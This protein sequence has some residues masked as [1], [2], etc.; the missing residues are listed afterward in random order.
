MGKW[1]SAVWAIVRKELTIE[2]HT[3]QIISVMLFFS[4]AAVVTF[5]L[6]VAG[7]LAAAR[8]VSAGL[9]WVT[10]LLAGTLGLNRSFTA[11]RE[12]HSFD[13]LLM[14]PI[15]RSA[16]YMGKVISVSLFTFAL[17]CL[18]IFVF[19]IFFGRPF[20]LPQIVG[21]LV[22]GTIGYVAA[23]VLVTSMTMQTRASEVLLPVLLLPLTLPAVLAAASTTA[24]YLFETNIGWEQV[25]FGISLILFYDVFMLM[26]GFF[27]YQFI[28]EE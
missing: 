23:G 17:E 1:W 13:A 3:G 8:N 16:I 27:T 6:A 12:N 22:L 15:A 20:W 25:G 14:A 26:V 21:V 9:L 10:I 2:R 11:E 18:L 28:V 24:R 19:T 7:D 4:L 5:N